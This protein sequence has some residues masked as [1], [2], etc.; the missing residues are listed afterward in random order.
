MRVKEK[1]GWMG[2]PWG[3]RARYAEAK[4]C[5][6]SKYEIYAVLRKMLECIFHLATMHQT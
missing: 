6:L 5:Q 4:Y 3:D 2:M 1:V